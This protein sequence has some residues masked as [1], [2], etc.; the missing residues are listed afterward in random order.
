MARS[1]RKEKILALTRSPKDEI[2]A[3]AVSAMVGLEFSL[4]K[5]FDSGEDDFAGAD[6]LSFEDAGFDEKFANIRDALGDDR[7]AFVE[8]L[9]KIHSL[10]KLN[11][12]L[13]GKK[14]ISQ[15]KTET[16]EAHRSDLAALKNMSAKIV[17]RSITL[18]SAGRKP[19]TKSRYGGRAGAKRKKERSLQLCRVHRHG[20]GQGLCQMQ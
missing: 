19:K 9:K 17:P 13:N 2:L 5:L 14:F 20:Q 10:A 11:N 18:F 1:G 12:I 8:S 3:N 15:A 7:A 4:K 6:K 16:Y